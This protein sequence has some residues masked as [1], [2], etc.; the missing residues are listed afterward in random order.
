M[1]LRLVSTILRKELLD[2][3]RDK[4]TL[5]M[6]LGVPILLYPTLL[7]LGFQVAL[8]QHERLEESES[9]VAVIAGPQTQAREYAE[10]AVDLI[11]NRLAAAPRI[12]V[13]D[14][15]NPERRLREG[16]LDAVVVVHGAELPAPELPGSISVEILFDATEF[17]S[18]EASARVNDALRALSEQLLSLRLMARGLDRAF[19]EP[20][21]LDRRDVAS[22]TKS[23][24]VLLGMLLPI[25]MV[26]MLA[27]GAFY[28][29][30]DLTAGEKERGTFETLLA[31]PIG[32]AEI[33]AGKFLA[34][35]L[36]AMLTG[37][38]NLASMAGTFLVLLGQLSGF[39]EE[40]IRFEIVLPPLAIPSMIV[41]M[42][43]LALFISAVMMSAAVLARSF[44]EA[45]NY[46][47][48]VFLAITLPVFVAAMPG[49][50]LTPG[51]AVLPIANVVL[52]FKEL[53]TGEVRLDAV[54]L[55][56]GVTTLYAALALALATRI[57]QREE[58]ILSEDAGLPLSW[59]RNDFAPRAALSPGG[60][61]ALFF[62][63][64]LL[65]FY[66]G[67]AIADWDLAWGIA[68]TQWALL[69]APC[70]LLLWFFR[71]RFREAL[72][73]RLPRPLH[74]AGAV[75]LGAGWV[76]FMIQL[77]VWQQRALPMPAPIAEHFNEIFRTLGAGNVWL[78]LFLLALSPAICEEVVCRGAM[79][80]GFRSRMG[81]VASVA[82]SGLLFAALHLSVHRFLTTAL[83]G[84]LLGFL[85]LRTRSLLTGVLVHFLNNALALLLHLQLVPLLSPRLELEA[86]ERAGLPLWLLA[87]A[88]LSVALGLA[89]LLSGAGARP[90][91]KDAGE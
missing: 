72:Y 26:V 61:F 49:V 6:M 53:L 58:V 23:T 62:I 65:M 63:V 87:G 16:R 64:I 82:L 75:L 79:L 17:A 59:R 30:V 33:I 78:L 81:P 1:R 14:A 67:N 68:A 11:A 76:F 41:V 29:A 52:L 69:L 84:F 5:V 36:L 50:K 54:V 12:Q 70:L 24:G 44:K 77:A 13:V 19:I 40:Q 22:P 4:R 32:K 60:A 3:V 38:L 15:P 47:T 88:G 46:L 10:D 2:T 8:I 80:S 90:A 66:A 43:P 7:I 45:Q 39:L 83:T 71:V 9:L 18:Q 28:P 86:I 21:R 35:F 85:V 56:F 31:T 73:L 51:A 89:A 57:F 74:L 37:L 20:V 48:P 91:E 42:I 55:V 34:V 27:L 25:I